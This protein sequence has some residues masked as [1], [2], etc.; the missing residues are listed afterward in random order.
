MEKLLGATETLALD[1]ELLWKPFSCQ[2][3]PTICQYSPFCW[4]IL[5]VQKTTKNTPVV[6]KLG[7]LLVARRENTH[8]GEPWVGYS[9]NRALEMT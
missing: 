9:N 5:V 3:F 6:R 1:R 4:T 2:Y 7:I 8:P